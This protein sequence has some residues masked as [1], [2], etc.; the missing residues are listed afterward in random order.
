MHHM[1]SAPKQMRVNGAL[2]DVV[3]TVTSPGGPKDITEAKVTVRDPQNDR[4][5]A[6]KF[7][8]LYP[9]SWTKDEIEQA[10]REAWTEAEAKGQVD[11]D[12]KWFGNTKSGVRIE[13]FL[14]YDQKSIAT[15]FPRY[16]RPRRDNRNP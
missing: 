12:G 14:S 16:Q 8:T 11:R 15:A 5:V 9:S 6:E 1:P 4:V 2:C 7:S 10:I 13:G 3:F